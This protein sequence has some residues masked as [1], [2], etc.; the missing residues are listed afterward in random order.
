MLNSRMKWA[1]V[2]SVMFALTLACS[3]K[4]E[5]PPA[6]TETKAMESEAKP[7]PQAGVEHA[8]EQAHQGME[9]THEA[10]KE[11]HEQMEAMHGEMKEGHQ[12][13]TETH[14]QVMAAADL[15][16]GEKIYSENCV[17][18][19]GQGIAGAPKVG[20]KAAWEERIAEGMDDLVQTA[21]NG[22][23]AMPPKGGNPA[24]SDEEV[25]AAV[26][27]MIEQSR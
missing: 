23:G 15:T 5:A 25:R 17:A 2:L 24:L 1:L 10:M 14:E 18:C 21:L 6:Q 11:S 19:H 3:K 7:A 22:E 13:M 16:L 26:G 8:K 12:A 20:D 27:Y 4:E 9:E